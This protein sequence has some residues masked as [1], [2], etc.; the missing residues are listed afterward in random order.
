M[1]KSAKLSRLLDLDVYKRVTGDDASMEREVYVAEI[2]RP[3]FELAGFFKHSDFRRIILLGEKENA[4]IHEMSAESQLAC[5]SKLV[6][7]ET[8]CIIIAKGYKAPDILKNIAIKRNFPIFETELPTGRV[9]ITLQNHLDELL[10]PETLMHGV[11]LNIY[12]K[13][14]IIRGDSGIGKSEIALELIKKGHQ[15]IADDAIELFHISS[16]IRGRSPKVLKNLLEIRGIGVIDVS[17][18]F[19]AG[20]VLDSD[21][22]EMII[23]LERWLPSREY[24]RIGLEEDEN[25]EDILGIPIHKIVVPVTGGRSMAAIIEA[26]VMNMQLRSS[27]FDSSKE[28]INRILANIKSKQES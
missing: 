24:Q 5:F 15:L 8:P 16:S 27:G 1:S 19:G 4:F 25:T 12:G 17:K 22:V 18:M 14:V 10:A 3:G 21:I 11:F 9:S 6:N 13:G 23:Q 7:D 2:N 20:S 28:F 26:A